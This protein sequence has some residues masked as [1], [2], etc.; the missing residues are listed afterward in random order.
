MKPFRQFRNPLQPTSTTTSGLTIPLESQVT[1]SPIDGSVDAVPHHHRF[2][3]WL[4]D[5]KD[6]ALHSADQ[7]DSQQLVHAEPAADSKATDSVGNNFIDNLALAAELCEKIANVVDKAPLVAPLA[8]LVS[9]I[10][11]TCKEIQDTKGHHNDLFKRIM[12]I[13]NNLHG[14]VIRMEKT[15]YEEDTGRLKADMEE[16]VRLINKASA[17]VSDF[18]ARANL[19]NTVTHKDWE[20]KLTALDRELDSFAGQFNVN[21]ETD[22]QIGQSVIRKK[23]DEVQVS[24]LATKLREWLQLPLDMGTKHGVTQKLDLKGT[25]SWFLDGVQFKEWKETS[26]SLWLEGQSGAGKTVLSSTVIEKL[27]TPSNPDIVPA[28]AVAY[29]YFDFRNEDT[30]LLEMMLRSIVFQL[31]KQSPRPYARLD[32]CYQTRKGVT[33][34]TSEDLQ[35]ILDKLL[36]E[37][38]RTYIVLDALDECKDTALIIQCISRLQNSSLHRLF[39]SQYRTE[40]AVAFKAVAHIILEPETTRDDIKCFVESELQTL[41]LKHWARHTTEITRKV[42]EKSNGMFRLAACLLIELSH[43]KTVRDSDTILANLPSALFEIYDRFLQPIHADDLPAVGILLRWLLFS[44]ERITLP[45]LEDALAFDFRPREH[46]FQPAKRD[47]YASLVCELLEG[48]VTVGE[49]PSTGN[50]ALTVV[51]LAHASVADYLMSHTFAEKHKCDLSSGLSHTFL[52]QSCVGYLLHFAHNPLNAMTLPDYPLASYAA[53]YWSHHLLV[54]HDRDALSSSTM[55]LLES[56][57][58]QYVALNSLHNYEWLFISPDWNQEA[59]VPLFI[60]SKIGYTEGVRFLLKKGADVST[61]NQ[62]LYSLSA[63]QV[64]SIEGHLEIVRLL[65]EKGAD[66][67]AGHRYTP[68]QRASE[69]GHTEIVRLLLKKGADCNTG[70]SYT[71][72]QCAS[73]NGH[74]EI[75]RL[76]LEK[77]ADFNA[78]YGY[79]PL[80]CASKAGNIEMVRLLLEKGADINA[81]YDTPLQCGSEA[82]HTEIVCRL[83]EKGADFNAGRYLTPLQCASKAGHT[84]IVRLLLKKGADLNEGNDDSPLQLVSRF[85]HTEI[86][87]LL[88]E[89]GADF[90]AGRHYTPLQWAS[91][92]GHT[93][94]VRL[95]L[96]KGH[97]EIVRLFLE[98]G[99]DI[100]AGRGYTP[101]QHASQGGHTEIVRLLLEK[102]A[103]INAG[104]DYTPLQRASKEGHTE[105]VCLLL[106]KGADINTGK[107]NSPLR[108]ASI[109]G[110]TEIVCLLLEK[111]ADGN[112]SH[113]TEPSA[114]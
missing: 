70:D 42:V 11:N 50:E 19:K 75:V 100:N 56:G 62:D 86:V 33:P 23:V 106:E 82:G 6:K 46:V 53:E 83:L 2:K 65:L 26:G 113:S 79:T 73:I 29:F 32:Q 61:V 3:E 22:F 80:Q 30:Q 109:Y 5:Q 104:N 98:K 12:K 60:C 7:L 40:F 15:Q 107:D 28:Y 59:P 41:K 10:L 78:G 81:G 94:T 31:S 18:D 1:K 89:K 102:G 90:N 111:G 4:R 87:R 71:P 93:K 105:I 21:R 47:N 20:R 8:A 48:L 64:A 108:L 76:L 38:G 84:E 35:D 99:A 74:T 9:T 39:T 36:M 96:E 77:G 97:T 27:L 17:L 58:R 91:M 43:R 85:G 44:A 66:F 14:T 67:N 114:S 110:H 92:E 55:H 52:A 49:A 112:T 51:G 57:S 68:L 95:L 72:L 24:G 103:D 37:L 63:L 101:L 54:C 16:Y 34:P 69:A 45:E 25:G 88:L 13:T